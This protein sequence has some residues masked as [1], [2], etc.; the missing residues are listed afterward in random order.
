MQQAAEHE[1][2]LKRRRE[3][4]GALLAARFSADLGQLWLPIDTVPH[5]QNMFHLACTACVQKMVLDRLQRD[6]WFHE[7]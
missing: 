1:L 4:I 6:R 3:S 2:R 7:Y 5:L